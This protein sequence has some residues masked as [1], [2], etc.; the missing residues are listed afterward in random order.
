MGGASSG[1]LVG[2]DQLTVQC[3][4]VAGTDVCDAKSEF[5]MHWE[6][7]N[8]FHHSVCREMTL[9]DDLGC[10]QLLDR[11]LQSRVREPQVISAVLSAVCALFPVVKHIDKAKFDAL[12]Q[13]VSLYLMKQASLN[14]LLPTCQQGFSKN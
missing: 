8:T 12:V 13:K 4:V 1:L 5:Y 11:L 7:I 14:H 10:L 3:F 6:A 2:G 9:T